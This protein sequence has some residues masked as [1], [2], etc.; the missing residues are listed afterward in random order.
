[1]KIYPNDSCPC[2]SGKKYK[3]CCAKKAIKSLGN[4]NGLPFYKINEDDEYYVDPRGA[5][6]FKDES[7]QPVL[8]LEDGSTIKMVLSVGINKSGK[9]IATIKENDGVIC[10]ILP[11]WYRDWCRSCVSTA[12]SGVNFFPARVEFCKNGDK[13]SADIL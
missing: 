12:M 11:A 9:P 1:M 13:Y 8:N 6:V 3:N 5:V 2:G 10:Y 7:K 4:F